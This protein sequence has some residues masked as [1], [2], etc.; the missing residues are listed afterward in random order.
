ML[1]FLKRLLGVKQAPLDYKTL[2]A[3]GAQI[4]DV[5]TPEEFATGHIPGAINIPVQT[6]DQDSG[7]LNKD[8]PVIICCASG[9][10]GITARNLLA[11]RGFTKVHNGG[12]WLRLNRKLQ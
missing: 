5:R 11:C 2:K 6:L 10:R 7:R 12:E 3:L 1:H 9:M 4:V 8:K